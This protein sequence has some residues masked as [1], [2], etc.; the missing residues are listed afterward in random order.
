MNPL[1]FFV[2]SSLLQPL[3][4]SDFFHSN[5]AVADISGATFEKKIR[6]TKQVTFVKFYAPWCGH[7]KNLAPT[8][9]KVADKLKD[10]A[11]IVSINCDQEENKPVCGKYGVQ[12]FP[13]L[14]LFPS[15][16]ITKGRNKEPIDYNGARTKKEIID[17]ITNAIPNKVYEVVK[18]DKDTKRIKNIDAFLK[19]KSSTGES[20]PK[21]ILF[22]DK[23]DTSAIYKSLAV[24]YFD[25]ASFGVIR[26]KSSELISKYSIEKF[27]SLLIVAPSSDGA[28][29]SSD[30]PIVYD[31]LMKYK[32]MLEFIGKYAL[33]KSGK[34]KKSDETST[35]KD[36]EESV[37]EEETPE[38]TT[39]EKE[40]FDPAV[41]ELFEQEEFEQKCLDDSGICILNLFFP[42]NNQEYIDKIT[43]IKKTLHDL[44]SSNILPSSIPK[45][46][47]HYSTIASHTFLIKQFSIPTEKNHPIT[48]IIQPRRQVYAFRAHDASSDFHDDL[49]KYLEEALKGKVKFFKYAFSPKLKKI[50]KA[51]ITSEKDE[52]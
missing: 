32:P 50:K 40:I 18:A 47:F 13:T 3:L 8:Y 27:P 1:H 44:K 38:V 2:I 28:D 45:V 14:K 33:L 35:K 48:L 17:F 43:N 5:S 34:S 23:S 29:N 24:E 52:L 39:P 16:L 49:Y 31:G 20:L 12:G 42:G 25:R 26:K 10:V 7:C 36:G 51:K 22:T 15:S 21:T 11:K 4:G 6:N 37:K 19:L 46:N 41:T 9:S 30:S